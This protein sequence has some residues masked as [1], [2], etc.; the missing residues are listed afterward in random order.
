M[1]EC[2]SN[3]CEWKKVEGK[4]NG[5]GMNV[6]EIHENWDVYYVYLEK[7]RYKEQCKFM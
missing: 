1:S 3:V 2:V 4:A 7:M 5:C 6:C